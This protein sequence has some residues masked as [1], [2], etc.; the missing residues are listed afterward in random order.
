M[1]WAYSYKPLT[2]STSSYRAISKSVST[3][4][5]RRVRVCPSGYTTDGSR[6]VKTVTTYSC[7]TGYKYSNGS[8]TLK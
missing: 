6:C 7:P 1:E 4:T 5:G 8:C 2:T 3:Y